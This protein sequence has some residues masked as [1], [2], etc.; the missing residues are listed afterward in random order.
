MARCRRGDVVQELCLSD[1]VFAPDATAGWI[2]AA[3]GRSLGLM[4]H[5][6]DLPHGMSADLVVT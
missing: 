2:H 5:P 1:L 6:A 3:Y 4:R